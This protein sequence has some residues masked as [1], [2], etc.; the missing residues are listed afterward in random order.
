[1]LQ[2]SLLPNVPTGQNQWLRVKYWRMISSNKRKHAYALVDQLHPKKKESLGCTSP[3]KELKYA[4][5]LGGK[6]M[7]YQDLCTWY[8][9]NV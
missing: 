4:K 5:K 9:R 6:F 3:P 7:E 2:T 8:T 1:M